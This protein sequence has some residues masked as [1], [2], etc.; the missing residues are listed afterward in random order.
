MTTVL[1]SPR[2]ARRAPDGGQALVEFALILPVALLLLVGLF[3][4]SRIVF[5]S[6]TLSQAVREGT[7]YAVVHGAASTAPTGPGAASYT[8]PN[9]DSTITAVVRGYAVGVPTPTVTA[10]WPSNNAYRGSDVFVTA[11]FPY[12]PVLSQAFLGQA[13]RV[14]LSA[15]SA[16]AIQQ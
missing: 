6:T 7:R 15:S 5:Y 1:R 3:D 16:L 10:V 11:T 14:T 4:L 9:T 2:A 13:L 8:G 12:V